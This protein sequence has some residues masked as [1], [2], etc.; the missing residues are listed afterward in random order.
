MQGRPASMAVLKKHIM[1]SIKGLSNGTNKDIQ[2]LKKTFDVRRIAKKFKSFSSIMQAS[3]FLK[4]LRIAWPS[5]AHP[6]FRNFLGCMHGNHPRVQ[7]M[8]KDGPHN[9]QA[10]VRGCLFRFCPEMTRIEGVEHFLPHNRPPP[11]TRGAERWASKASL[12]P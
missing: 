2:L 10:K 6:T 9:S 7:A 12:P 4:K 11:S 1:G 8:G 3:L 5:E